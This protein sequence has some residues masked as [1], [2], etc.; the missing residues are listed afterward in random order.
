MDFLKGF[1]QQQP[2]AASGDNI[3]YLNGRPYTSYV[4]EVK[5]LKRAGNV[6]GAE[7]L[8]LAI[9]EVVETEARI[10]GW[11]VAPWYYE[12]LAKLYR[13]RKDY[14]AEVAILQRYASQ[15]HAPGVVPQQLLERLDKAKALLAE[16]ERR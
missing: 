10:K 12:E 9:I 13:Q 2:V 11:G 3:G 1:K 7:R 8:L 5:Q 14:R 6:E 16:S 4:E 15:P